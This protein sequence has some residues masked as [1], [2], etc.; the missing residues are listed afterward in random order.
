M[1]GCDMKSLT[2]TEARAVLP[3]LLR[4]VENGDQITITRH[5]RAI[6]VLVRPEAVRH[7]RTAAL[8]NSAADIHALLTESGAGSG[9]ASGLSA[10]RGEEL[11]RAIR[12][13]RDAG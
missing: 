12:V 7:D 1:Y 3:E 4:R 13:G 10:E 2:V 6:A 5:G 9:E 8:L 11:V